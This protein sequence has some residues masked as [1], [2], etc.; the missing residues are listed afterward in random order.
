MSGHG[1]LSGKTYLQ[2]GESARRSET[3]IQQSGC[4]VKQRRAV[5]HDFNNVAV[6]AFALG[7]SAEGEKPENGFSLRY[8][9][10]KGTH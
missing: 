5:S 2:T 4:E 10:P 6:Q 3:R 1:E 8:G 9:P 7:T